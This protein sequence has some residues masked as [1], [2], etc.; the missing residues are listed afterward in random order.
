M[1][2]GFLP[3]M[4]CDICHKIVRMAMAL[5]LLPHGRILA[6]FH[7]LVVKA[8]TQGK[9]EQLRPFFEYVRTVWMERIGPQTISVFRLANRTNAAMESSHKSAH[10]TLDT[11]H[12]NAIDFL[13]KY[14]PEN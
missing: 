14:E 9:Y 8:E 5:A 1:R 11:S 4:V 12:P 13:C 6:A 2:L 7:H 10:K 3:F